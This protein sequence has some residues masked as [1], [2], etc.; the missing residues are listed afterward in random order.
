MNTNGSTPHPRNGERGPSARA[1]PFNADVLAGIGIV[2]LGA[3]FLWQALILRE[4]PGYAAVGPRVFPVVVGL[5]LLLSGLAIS[6]TAAWALR[7]LGAAGTMAPPIEG[8][9]AEPTDWRTLIA[10]AAVLAGYV[11]LFLPLGF[12]LASTAFLV[13]SARILGSRSPL[14]D[15]ASGLGLSIVAYLVFTRLLGL[16]LPAGLLELPMHAAV[17]AAGLAPGATARLL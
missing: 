2:V 6:I 7:R 16:E 11:A 15:L 9:T 12:I 3:W 13:A 5:G 17:H 4:G 14:R 10:E 8:E 1:F